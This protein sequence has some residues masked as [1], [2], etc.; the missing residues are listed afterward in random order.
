[1][2]NSFAN[3]LVGK[4]ANFNIFFFTDT[5]ISFSVLVIN[6]NCIK[7][8]VIITYLPVFVVFIDSK[9]LC[10]YSQIYSILCNRAQS[11]YYNKLLLNSMNNEIVLSANSYGPRGGGGVLRISSDGHDRR[12]FWGLKFSIPGFFR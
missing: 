1:M 3:N 12:I 4:Y 5:P 8:A 9:C 10:I 6:N 7:L 2:R 11:C